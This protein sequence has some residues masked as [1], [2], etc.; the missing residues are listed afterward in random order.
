MIKKV[1]SGG[2]T[3]ADTAGLAAAYDLGFPTGGTAPLFYRVQTFTGEDSTNPE[4]KVKYGL[5]ESEAYNWAPRTKK[6]VEYSDGTVWVGFADSGG[7]RL[8]LSTCTDLS[9]P[10]IVNPIVEEL[11]QWIIDN[12]IEILNVAGNRHSPVN[13]DIYEKTYDL[14]HKALSNNE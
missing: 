14:I 6:N 7:G 5:S 3:G 1:I 11:K 4:L 13:P 8:T 12:N 9:K 2:Q 10:F